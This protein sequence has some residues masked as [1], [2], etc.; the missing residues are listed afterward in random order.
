M[1]RLT[2]PDEVIEVE[3]GI[4]EF[5]T[6]FF[7]TVLN[8]DSSKSSED[9]KKQ[10]SN[11]ESKIGRVAAVT[12]LKESIVSL[13]KCPQKN[14]IK[15]YY[16][17]L[18][19]RYSCLIDGDVPTPPELLPESSTLIREIFDYFYESLLDSKTF[20][21]EY[22]PDYTS[23]LELKV[24][25]RDK[26]GNNGKVCPYCDIQWIGHASHSSIDHFFPKSR[27][28]LLSIFVSNLIVSCTG[29]NDR[30][31]KANLLLPLF[32]PYFHQAADYFEFEINNECNTI[33]QIKLLSN[34]ED[35]VRRVNN[36]FDLFNLNEMYANVLYKVR[37]DRR[38]LRETV[39]RIYLA[40]NPLDD[41]EGVLRNILA[42]EINTTLNRNL[43]KRGYFDLTKIKHDFFQSLERSFFEVE[44]EYLCSHLKL[45]RITENYTEIDNSNLT[46]PNMIA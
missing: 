7:E 24:Y 26:M 23:D 28:P 36:Y 37:E 1:W 9:L 38:Q 41:K 20:R 16:V 4:Q 12:N 10:V 5:I 45:D 39:K 43:S 6:D 32:H 14:I 21:Q 25:L 19:S 33:M 40:Y 2:I 42:E 3:R 13:V 27:F 31:K 17:S 46:G 29:C 8:S 22:I 30:I 35:S 15:M 34:H 18:T 11:R 44:L